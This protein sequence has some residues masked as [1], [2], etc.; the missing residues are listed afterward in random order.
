M[1]MPRLLTGIIPLIGLSSC[2][3]L[4]PE[5][6]ALRKAREE[7]ARTMEAYNLHQQALSDK[8]AEV[9]N[10]QRQLN[11]KKRRIQKTASTRTRTT[12]TRAASPA[13]SQEEA[14]IRALQQQ[15]QQK[16]AELRTLNQQ[17]NKIH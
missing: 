3:Y 2:M 7:H 15:L 6:R 5:G 17:I 1:L 12:T 16:E 10:L 9:A 8:K 11:A 4:L 14:E 13:T